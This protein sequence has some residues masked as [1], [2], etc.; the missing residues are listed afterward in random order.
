LSYNNLSGRIPSGHQ[1]DTLKADDP[2]SVYIGN[3]SLCGYPLPKGLSWRSAN[4]KKPLKM[5]RR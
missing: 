4:T 5:E 3:P 2:A 1:L